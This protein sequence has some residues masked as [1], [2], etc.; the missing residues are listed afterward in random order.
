MLSEGKYVKNFSLVIIGSCQ[1]LKTSPGA[2]SLF[3]G[4]LGSRKGD[5]QRLETCESTDHPFAGFHYPFLEILEI[6]ESRNSRILIFCLSQKC[7][8]WSP[9]DQAL[10]VV[11]PVNSKDHL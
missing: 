3:Q 11:K 4:T 6:L 5:V 10:G 7:F 8:S 9:V 1:A 2:A